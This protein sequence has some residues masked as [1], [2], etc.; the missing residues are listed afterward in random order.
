MYLAFS[1]SVNIDWFTFA[2]G[3]TSEPVGT[4]GDLNDDGSVNSTD[5]SI[6]RR[7]ILDIT[8]LTGNA[9]KNADV[10]Q[11]GKVDSTDYALMRRKILG[12]IDSF[13]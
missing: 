4:L 13:N 6:L 8:P 5:Y 1:N 9:L 11:S 3:S 10:N 7:H 12:I 2:G